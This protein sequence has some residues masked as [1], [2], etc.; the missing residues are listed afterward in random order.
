MRGCIADHLAKKAGLTAKVGLEDAAEEFLSRRGAD[1]LLAELKEEFKVK[2]IL[3]CH[4]QLAKVPWKRIYTTNYDDVVEAAYSANGKSLTPV[5]LRDNIRDLSKDTPL[6]VHLN[7]YV[8]RLN[9]DNV[10]SEIKLTDTSYLTTSVTESPWAVLFRQDLESAQVVFFV[11]YSLWDLDIRRVV[12]ENDALRNKTFFVLGAS[13]DATIVRRAQR[14]GALTGDGTEEFAKRLVTGEIDVSPELAGPIPYCV[15]RYEPR[16]PSEKLGDR[17][18]FDLL[19][20]GRLR[21]DFVWSSMH[22]GA[23][24]CQVR[25]AAHLAMR[26]IEQGGSAVILHADLANGKTVA[27]ETLKCMAA[28]RQYSVF[29][30]AKQAESLYE[31]LEHAFA[32]PGKK[33]FFIDNYPDWISALGLFGTHAPAETTLVLSARTSSNDVLAD[34]AMQLLGTGNVTEIPTDKLS[35][36]ELEWLVQYFSEYGLWG[37]LAARSHSK[38]IDY[39]SRICGAQWHAILIKLL[40]SPQIQ[41][42]LQAWFVGLREHKEHTDVIVSIL[43]LTVI[44]EQPSPNTLI[45]LCGQMIL[46]SGFRRDPIIRDFVDFAGNEVRMKSSVAA[47]YMLQ[48]IVDPNVTVQGLVSLAKAADRSAGASS[49]YFNI[50]KTLMRYSSLQALLPEKSGRRMALTYYESIKGLNH[51]KRAP[52]FWLQYAIAALLDAE[53]TEEFERAEK[54]FKTAYSFAEDR[55][56][57]DSVQIDN[58]YA[59]FLLMRAISLGDVSTCMAAFREARKLIH[60]QIERERLHYGYRVA[61]LYADFYEKFATVLQPPNREEIRRAAKHV[62]ERIEKLPPERQKQR[63]VE[64]CW[65]VLQK[66]LESPG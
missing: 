5:T 47:Q 42:R 50:V 18:I 41:A 65:D 28:D 21:D 44:G 59:R 22:G 64:N 58:Q 7:G 40:E 15:A 45:D 57:W 29:T 34:R 56:F 9:R 62:C 32:T 46:E 11:G 13:P 37:D 51:A 54:Y 27:L 17:S 26:R 33:L 4:Q 6:C 55:E 48:H 20:Y 24:Y 30:V 3:G 38:K 14:F 36:A 8:N 1:A 52:L 19:L 39:L 61:A 49:Y 2:R 12:S 63:Y 16:P 53:K 25:E 10:A 31:E 60:G 66:I 35:A 23:R 43:I